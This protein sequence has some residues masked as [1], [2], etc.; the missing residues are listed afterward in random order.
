MLLKTEGVN[1]TVALNKT[2]A[3]TGISGKGTGCVIYAN[4]AVNVTSNGT[5]YGSGGE[6]FV[7]LN[8][9]VPASVLDTALSRI[10]TAFKQ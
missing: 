2:I 3:N 1:T 9:G 10:L 5:S 8:I 7:R 4:G 6:G